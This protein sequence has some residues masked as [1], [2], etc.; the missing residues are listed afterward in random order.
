MFDTRLVVVRTY[1]NRFEADLAKSALDAADIPAMVR[2]DD[3]GGLRPGLWI[4]NRVVLLV[5]VE[6][7]E[8]AIEILD[9]PARPRPTLHRK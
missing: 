3:A 4:G 8:Q 9:T 6:D 2:A 7:S 1:S 5:N